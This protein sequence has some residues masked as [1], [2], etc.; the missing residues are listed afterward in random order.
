MYCT[1]ED[2]QKQVNQDVLERV[3]GDEDGN[4]L[5]DV[6]DYG[7]TQASA[8]ID[9]YCSR[10]TLPFATVPEVL[11]KYCVDM[12]LFHIFSRQGFRFTEESEDYV[13]YLRYKMA[14]DFL[15]QVA[16]GKVDLPVSGSG[17]AGGYGPGTEGTGNLRIR[18]NERLFTRN[19]MGGY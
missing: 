12:A 10:Y 19:K 5:M 7:I 18:S 16:A 6:I 8:E 17:D 15:K 1:V 14:L 4:L 11:K 2:L 9:A 3:A 13:I